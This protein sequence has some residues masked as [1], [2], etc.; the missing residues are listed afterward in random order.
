MLTIDLD[1]GLVA[2]LQFPTPRS[3]ANFV[4]VPGTAQLPVQFVRGG[5]A[6]DLGADGGGEFGLKKAGHFGDSFIV[7]A[8]SWTK[9][10]SGVNAVYTFLVNWNTDDLN[11]LLNIADGVV[12]GNASVTLLGGITWIDAAG[13]L[14]EVIFNAVVQNN[15]FHGDEDV[16]LD[17]TVMRRGT[18]ALGNGVD[19]AQVTGLLMATVPLHVL[20]TLRK[21]TG[22]LNLF[23]IVRSDSISTDGF[24][25]DLSAATDADTYVL[26]WLI[27]LI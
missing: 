6:Q 10:G 12:L 3:S 25:V 9:A 2:S 14:N 8:S 5:V 7:I 16:S 11:A 4:R 21:V 26:D 23:A 19:H 13:K 15:V 27:F 22:G 24:I 20:V 1:T 17:A 18:L